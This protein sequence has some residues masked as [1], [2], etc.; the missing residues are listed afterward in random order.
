MKSVRDKIVAQRRDRIVREGHALGSAVPTRREA[1]LVPF[2]RPP[3][4]I[5]EIK[6][7]SPSRGEIA[8]NLDPVDRA[9][10]YTQAGITSISVLTEEDHFGGSLGDLIAVKKAYPHAALLRKDFLL[11]EEDIQISYRAGADAVLLIAS[12]LQAR[13][14]ARL[15]DAATNLGM[16][17]LVELHEPDDFDK[18]RAVAPELIGINA[19]DLATFHVDLLTPVALHPHVDWPHRAVFESGVS[20]EEDAAIVRSSGFDGVLV[21]E[22]VVKNPTVI[23]GIVRGM[24]APVR[25]VG[26]TESHRTHPM[27][28]HPQSDFWT[29][30]MARRRPP[31]PLV[32]ICGITNRGD[33]ELAVALGADVLGF[34]FADSK[35]RTDPAFVRSLADLAVLKVGVVVSGGRHGALAAPVSSLL[36][37]GNLDAVQFHGDEEPAD[38]FAQAFPYFKTVRVPLPRSDSPGVA[39]YRSPRVLVDSRHESAYGGT[40]VR[41]APAIVAELHSEKPLWLAGGLSDA[42]IARTIIDFHPELVDASSGLESA[43]GKKDREK[44]KLY[45]E[46]IARVSI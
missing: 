12:I 35:R 38:C 30:L 41:V 40:G 22:A 11:D 21:G 2:L 7:R 28:L 14:L 29:R 10:R 27:A 16:A 45:F 18:A 37:G 1:P 24:G 23:P 17:A 33:A 34:V 4:V 15:H 6:R 13:E 32:K 31:R 43:P 25:G 44:L 39:D 36:S 5:C 8:A 3:H 46:E 26:A 20:T 9:R 42:N 19:R